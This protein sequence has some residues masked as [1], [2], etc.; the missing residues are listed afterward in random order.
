MGPEPKPKPRDVP[1]SLPLE[2]GTEVIPDD[3]RPRDSSQRSPPDSLPPLEEQQSV[4]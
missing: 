1:D 4:E 3:V 2:P